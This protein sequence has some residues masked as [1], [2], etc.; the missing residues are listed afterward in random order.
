MEETLL[1]LLI[2]IRFL[3]KQLVLLLLG[4]EELGL[5]DSLEE[6]RTNEQEHRNKNT[7]EKEQNLDRPLSLHRL[8]SGHKRSSAQRASG[9]VSVC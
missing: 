9:G 2:S 7:E 1:F 5:L 6:R 8:P 4:T 3:G